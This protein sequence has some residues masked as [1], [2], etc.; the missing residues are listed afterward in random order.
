MKTILEES[1]FT[2]NL[3]LKLRDQIINKK[4]ISKKHIFKKF[5]LYFFFSFCFILLNYILSTNILKN[6]FNNN[7]N[8]SPAEINDK[9]KSQKDIFNNYY[10]FIKFNDHL[11]NLKVYF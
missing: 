5:L 6:E 7:S 8:Q 10:L 11:H 4:Y 2:N 1:I 9:S 3:I